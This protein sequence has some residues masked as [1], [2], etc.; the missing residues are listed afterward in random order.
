M[1]KI[2]GFAPR[3]IFDGGANAGLWAKDARKHY[4]EAKIV[5]VE[6]QPALKQSLEKWAD[7]DGNAIVV[8]SALAAEAGTLSFYAKEKG[9]TGGSAKREKL[10]IYK[11]VKP[12]EVQA[13]TIDEIL[14]SLGL[15]DQI[16]LVKLDIQ[17]VDDWSLAFWW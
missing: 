7:A 9:A 11:D 8:S 14:T 16:D 2:P 13:R 4:P 6:A 3:V 1:K 17:V 10:A 12:Y 15:L 5:M